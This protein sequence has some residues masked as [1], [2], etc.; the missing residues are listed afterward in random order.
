V[1]LQPLN[2]LYRNN[3]ATALV[4]L[5]RADKAF[6]HLMAVHG[7]AVAHYNLG[8]LLWKAKKP[9]EARQQFLAALAVDPS[10]TPAR[11]VLAQFSGA[12]S[13][14]ALGHPSAGLS[15]DPSRPA[16]GYPVP[17]LPS[18]TVPSRAIRTLPPI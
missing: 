10:L 6:Q 2:K 11:K 16:D 12:P 7:E 17:T 3:L 8:F 14:G 18:A 15:N 4:E 13:D 1:E 5:G 9:E